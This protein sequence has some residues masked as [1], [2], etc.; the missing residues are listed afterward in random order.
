[1]PGARR[2]AA[3][4][5]A[6]ALLLAGSGTAHAQTVNE[7]GSTTLWTAELIVAENT[8]F[9]LNGD[10][11]YYQFGSPTGSLEPNSFVY[12]G[13]TFNMQFFGLRIA[14]APTPRIN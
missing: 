5:L 12:D 14:N 6:G 4:L 13:T 9:N 2:L 3:G 8:G 11:G 7:D 10:F 1:M